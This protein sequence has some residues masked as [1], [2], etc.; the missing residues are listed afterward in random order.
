MKEHTTMKMDCHRKQMSDKR[1]TL[2][3][4]HGHSVTLRCCHRVPPILIEN[5]QKKQKKVKS[6]KDE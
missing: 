4:D 5:H 6:L 1:C 3:I 2:N